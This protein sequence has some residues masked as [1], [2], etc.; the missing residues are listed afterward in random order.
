MSLER[1]LELA[2]A[3]RGRAYPNPTVGAVVVFSGE[4]VGEGAT[5][6]HG[7]R[8]GEVIALDAA[9]DRAR[10]ATLYLTMEPCTHHGR[11]P[12]CVERVLAAG[13]TRVVAG[14][15]D[16]NPKA[17]G[18]LEQLR[19]AGVEVELADSAEARRQ[20]EAWRTWVRLGGLRHVQGGGDARRPSRRVRFAL[21]DREGQSPPRP[22][23]ARGFGRGRG[24]NED[25]PRGFARLDAHAVT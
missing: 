3:A 9:G 10:G 23:V 11:T 19:E 12:P 2:A 14:S 1:A 4:V 22:R 6:E 17:G 18:G 24:R 15:L 20:N 8:H 25:V 5:E 13:V 16:P 21:G 7:G